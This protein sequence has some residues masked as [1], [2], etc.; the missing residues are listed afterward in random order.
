MWS[1]RHR[2]SSNQKSCTHNFYTSI[3]PLPTRATMRKHKAASGP[4]AARNLRGSHGL[5]QRDMARIPTILLGVSDERLAELQSGLRKVWTRFV[6]SSSPM[7]RKTAESFISL[8]ERYRNAVTRA[9]LLNLTIPSTRLSPEPHTGSIFEDDV[10]ATIM[11]FL[12]GRL[13]KRERS[14]TYLNTSSA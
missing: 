3:P 11:G 1:P 7:F 13:L 8:G 4:H 14:E 2:D 10:F 12:Y 6:Y 5:G 9:R